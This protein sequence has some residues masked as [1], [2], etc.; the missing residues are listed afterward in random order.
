MSCAELCS[1]ISHPRRTMVRLSFTFIGEIKNDAAIEVFR[2][3]QLPWDWDAPKSDARRHI[4]QPSACK[5][6]L[7]WINCRCLRTSHATW[8][9]EA[10]A[11]PKDVQGQMRHSRVSTTM[12]I[13]AAVRSRVATARFG[14]DVGDGRVSHVQADCTREHTQYCSAAAIADGELASCNSFRNWCAK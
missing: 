11:N 12:D 7:P 10:G 13:Y 14:E 3:R 8:M 1:H 4:K 6:S 5:I 9:V 2:K